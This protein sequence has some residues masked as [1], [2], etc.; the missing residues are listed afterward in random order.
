MLFADFHNYLATIK[1]NDIY[2][3]FNCY[4]TALVTV[5]DLKSNILNH[6]MNFLI[7]YYIEHNKNINKNN[8]IEYYLKNYKDDF[9]TSF[10]FRN[11]IN[12]I[13]D[14]D[15]YDTDVKDHYYFMITKNPPKPEIDYDELD[16]KFYLEEEEK[17]KLA[18]EEINYTDYDEYYY[19][20]Y[21]NDYED[22]DDEEYYDD[23]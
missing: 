10:S 11:K 15:D 19:E 8:L 12:I 22:Y 7:N 21:Y 17:E 13:E 14:D 1:D 23:F 20:E 9:D 16:K 3:Y 2:D 4:S 5:K 18:K 6:R